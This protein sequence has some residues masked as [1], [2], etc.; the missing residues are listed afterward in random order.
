MC[1]TSNGTGCTGFTAPFFQGHTKLNVGDFVGVLHCFDTSTPVDQAYMDTGL[2]RD[3]IK[4]LYDRV[5]F[6]AALV[7]QDQRECAPPIEDNGP[8]P[9]RSTLARR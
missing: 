5:R 9:P 3:T 4:L 1:R 6:A 8:H 2:N 7:T